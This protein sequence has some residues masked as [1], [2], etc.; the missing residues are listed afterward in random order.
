MK[1]R[2]L[3][4]RR[5][6]SKMHVASRRIEKLMRK[7]ISGVTGFS[8]MEIGLA[9]KENGQRNSTAKNPNCRS[10]VTK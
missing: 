4:K 6:R 7:V 2:G 9:C 8:G 1:K 10:V 5:S 3:R